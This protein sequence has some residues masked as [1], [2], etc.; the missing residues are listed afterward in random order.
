MGLSFTGKENDNEIG[1]ITADAIRNFLK[2]V[3]IKSVKSM[4]ICKEDFIGITPMVFQDACYNFVPKELTRSELEL[5]LSDVY[6]NY[7]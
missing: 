1:E 2:K 7:T 4:G 3:T 6:D 5:V